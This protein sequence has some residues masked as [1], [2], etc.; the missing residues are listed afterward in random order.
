MR[1]TG[2]LGGTFDPIHC[3]HL[4]VARAA[5]DALGLTEIVVITSNLPPHRPAPLA[6]SYHRFAMAALAVSNRPGWRVSD[7]ELQSPDPSYTV[8]TLRRFRD[9]G[10]EAEDLFFL[11]GA[12]AFA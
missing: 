8:T 1:R 12:D 10:Y 11:I 5:Q 9:E 6:S 4:D 3:G 7:V 2:I